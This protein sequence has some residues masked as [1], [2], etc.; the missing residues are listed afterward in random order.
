[1]IIDKRTEL[2]DA[3][4]LATATG[5]NNEADQEIDLSITSPGELGNGQPVYVVVTVDT[6][7]TSGTSSGVYFQLVSDSSTTIAT[8]GTQTVHGRSEE[9]TAATS[10]AAGTTF[11]FPVNLAS[12]ERYLGFQCVVADAVLTGGAVSAFLSL[13]P[14]GWTAFAD[15]DNAN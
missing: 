4:T 14:H 15:A 6:A 13:D 12:A 10:I 5:T 9:A 2:A 8:D 3:N 1:M 7:I 11:V